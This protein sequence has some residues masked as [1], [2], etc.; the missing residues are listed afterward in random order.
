MGAGIDRDYDRTRLHEEDVSNLWR[1]NDRLESEYDL[2]QSRMIGSREGASDL[3][4]KSTEEYAKLL[5]ELEE[6]EV[7]H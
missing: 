1:H 2:L 5:A 7:R 3:E 4:T 6:A